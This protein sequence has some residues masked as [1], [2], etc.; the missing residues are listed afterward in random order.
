MI[1]PTI[2]RKITSDVTSWH[3]TCQYCVDTTGV[4]ARICRQSHCG[5]SFYRGIVLTSSRL[6][7][8]TL[9]EEVLVALTVCTWR[10]LRPYL[11]LIVAIALLILQRGTTRNIPLPSSSLHCNT[12]ATAL[13]GLKTKH[14]VRSL[15]VL[16]G[17]QAQDRIV[18]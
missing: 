13:C 16:S 3:D 7:S 9:Y 14:I 18:L 1:N 6:I 4:A 17:D 10:A 15:R 11:A 12:S 2:P 5:K 8:Q